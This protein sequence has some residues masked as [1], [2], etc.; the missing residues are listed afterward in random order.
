MS[1][2]PNRLRYHSVAPGGGRRYRR[3]NHRPPNCPNTSATGG[4]WRT[5]AGEEA[6]SARKWWRKRLRMVIRCFTPLCKIQFRRPVLKDL[7]YDPV[8]S[9]SR[10]RGWQAGII[11]SGHPSSVPA[12]SVKELIALAKQKPGELIFGTS[13]FGASPI[14]PPSS[15]QIMADIDVKIVHL[16]GSGQR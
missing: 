10:F 8:K 6:S 4:T 15:F 13:G 11:T 16:K 9:L 14:C 3:T 1:I 2:Q 7:P 5:T 12:N